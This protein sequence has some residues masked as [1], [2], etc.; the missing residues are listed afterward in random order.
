LLL[1]NWVPIPLVTVAA[2]GSPAGLLTESEWPDVVGSKTGSGGIVLD[3][4]E[5][6]G[7]AL[8]EDL[9]GN[10]KVCQLW[11]AL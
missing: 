5:K 3:A 10:P 4:D 6:G 11:D 9:Y 2:H 7:H 1:A 8:E